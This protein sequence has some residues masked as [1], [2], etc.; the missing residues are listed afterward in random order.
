MPIEHT[1]LRPALRQ[2]LIKPRLSLTRV[3][4]SIGI[5]KPM[6]QGFGRGIV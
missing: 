2:P 5:R 4:R 6:R 3:V 1:P